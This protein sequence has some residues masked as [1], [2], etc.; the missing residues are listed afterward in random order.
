[1]TG[2]PQTGPQS[3]NAPESMLFE[4]NAPESMLFPQFGLG[5]N[6]LFTHTL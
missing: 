5:I 2:C 3:C 6:P 4:S 1:M